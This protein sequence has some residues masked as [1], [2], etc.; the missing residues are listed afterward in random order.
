[1]SR[2]PYL[3]IR[4]SCLLDNYPFPHQDVALA[5]MGFVLSD[6]RQQVMVARWDCIGNSPNHPR[7]PCQVNEQ[8]VGTLAMEEAAAFL[9]RARPYRQS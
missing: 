6:S 4:D 7:P 3:K 1:M 8:E 9:H 2:P 5:E